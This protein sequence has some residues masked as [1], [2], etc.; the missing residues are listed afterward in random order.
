MAIVLLHWTEH[1]LQAHQVY[2]Q[3]MPRP[4]A[5]GGLGMV[6]PWLVSSEGLHYTYALVMLA[7]LIL[8]RPGFTGR[9]R[10]RW[11]LALGIQVW[12]HFEHFLLLSQVVLHANIL[13]R[14]A[15]TS[16]LQLFFPRMEL[17][18]FYNALVFI[19]MVVAVYYHLNPPASDRDKPACSCA[20]VKVADVTA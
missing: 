16:I 14:A 8:L 12:H 3:G 17:H 2:V 19:P 9:A 5:L 18:L 13:G 6:F 1:L 7:G 11:N 10:A 20:R 15:P 4:Q